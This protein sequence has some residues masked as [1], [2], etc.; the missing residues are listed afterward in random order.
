M[1]LSISEATLINIANEMLSKRFNPGCDGLLP[2]DAIKILSINGETITKEVNNGTYQPKPAIRF[3]KLKRNGKERLLH[4]Y[5]ILDVIIQKAIS[6]ALNDSLKNYMS[7]NSYAYQ[8][9]KGVEDAIA[10]YLNY[11]KEYPFVVKIDPVDCYNNIDRSILFNVLENMYDESGIIK[12]IQNI[13][14]CQIIDETGLTKNDVGILQG[15]SIGPVLCNLYFSGLD[16]LLEEKCISFCRFADDI[17][18]FAKSE[19][20]AHNIAAII[21][22]YIVNNLH[23]R[24]NTEKFNICKSAQLQYLGYSFERTVDNNLFAVESEK[25][26]QFFTT[27]W[28]ERYIGRKNKSITL[29]SDG[30]LTRKDFNLLLDSDNKNIFPINNIDCINVYGAVTIAPNTIKL[31]AERNIS[32]NFFNN[33]GNLIGT[34]QPLNHFRNINI[35]L[36]QLQIYNDKKKRLYYAKAF[37]L[38]SLHNIRLNIRNYKK[39]Y[40]YDIC[41]TVLNNINDIANKIKS[42]KEIEEIL[43]LEAQMREQY[44]SCFDIFIRNH[45]FSFHKRTRRPPKNEFNCLISFGNTLLYNYIATE[46]CKSTLDIRIGFLH[47]TNSRT[48]SLNLD[49]ADMFKPLII[50][51]LV[52]SLINKRIISPK[53]HFVTESNGGVFLNNEG[54]RIFISFFYD[55]LSKK[56]TVGD[57]SMPYS[58][59][60]KEEIQKLVQ[61]IRN[62]EKYRGFRQVR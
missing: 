23:L 31:L 1:N 59:I 24:I 30:I 18:A 10:A 4:K 28:S 21:I 36:Q 57:S 22:D 29:L 58:A 35:P 34:F 61:S 26:E 45:S 50:D 42:A 32:I 14:L 16:F 3:V 6:N 15:S 55:K 43:L 41:S 53:I 25:K 60:I 17:V 48:K 52:F 33:Y 13:L 39:Q 9:G 47:A 12:T 2:V 56:V 5:C 40:S 19:A 27:D 62:N 37:V 38:S 11:A 44:Y 51:R 49:I 46:I 54:K 20:E 7:N 8:T